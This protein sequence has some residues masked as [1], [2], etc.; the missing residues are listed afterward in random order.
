MSWQ[1]E[2][3]DIINNTLIS[4]RFGRVYFQKTHHSTST[5]LLSSN[6]S[7]TP[8]V[9][10]GSGRTACDDDGGVREDRTAGDGVAES[11]DKKL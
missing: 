2:P 1:A 11:V 4:L 9:G 8:E 5:L 10:A 7:K 6:I 3:S